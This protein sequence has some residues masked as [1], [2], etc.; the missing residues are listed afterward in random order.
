MGLR[1]LVY[2][3]LRKQAMV[4]EINTEKSFEKNFRKYLEDMM[5]SSYL[6]NRFPKEIGEPI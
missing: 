1:W 3:A 2:N 5:K 4:N 6:C